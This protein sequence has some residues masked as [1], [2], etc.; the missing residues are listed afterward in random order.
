VEALVLP[1]SLTI[2]KILSQLSLKVSKASSH[3][4][5]GSLPETLAEL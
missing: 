2:I 5:I 4:F 3:V 1:A